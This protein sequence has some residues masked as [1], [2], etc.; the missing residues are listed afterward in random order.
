MNNYT[1]FV[2]VV[3]ILA[4]TCMA[5]TRAGAGEP[6]SL[7]EP[8]DVLASFEKRVFTLPDGK[9]MNG[10][11][12]PGDGPVLVL[13][14]GTWGTVDRFAALFAELPRDLPV[15][16]IELCW[17]GGQVPPTLELSIEQLADDV[18][19]VVE[20]LGLERFYIGGHSIGGMIAVEIAGRDVPGLAGVIAM[21]GWT[22]HTVVQTAFHGEVVGTLSPEQREVYE[23]GRTRGRAHLSEAQLEAIGVIWKQWN[24]YDSLL[25]SRV[26]ILHLWG[27]RGKPRPGREALQI[28]EQEN[29][30][31]AWIEGACHLMLMETPKAVAERVQ[32]FINETAEA[33]PHAPS[34]Q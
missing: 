14:P 21:E 8:G 3:G 24:G 30:E 4:V 29:I 20:A 15:A 12:R 16:V 9:R 19:W 5:L 18:L 22:H 23:A 13:V 10:Y 11:Q 2:L 31:V 28:P 32:S 33:P 27:D 26:P 25:R 1:A 6:A 34:A 7:P 17:Q